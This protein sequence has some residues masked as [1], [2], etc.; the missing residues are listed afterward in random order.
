MK[1]RSHALPLALAILLSTLIPPAFAQVPHFLKPVNYAVPGASMAVLADVNGDGFVDLITA[2]G[3]V[4]TGSG[5]SVLLGKGNGKFG[6]ATTIVDGGNPSYLVVGDFNHDGELDIAVANQPNPNFPLIPPT[7]GG[8]PHNSVSIL[9]G[10]GDGTFKP[11]IDTPTVGA[12]Q[13]VAADFN[14]DGKLDLAVLTG[15][16]S[17]LQI[18]LGNG[19]GTFA[20]NTTSVLVLSAGIFAGDFNHDGKQD[21]LAAGFELL[22]NGDG[23]FTT[24]PA[25]PP[26]SVVGDFNGDGILDLAAVVSNGGGRNPVTFFGETFFG[27][28]DGTW[29]LDGVFSIFTSEGNLIAAN[30]DGDGKLDVFG[31]GSAFPSPANQLLGGLFLGHGDGTFT[32]ASGGI[33]F[34]GFDNS[35]P[36]P[37]FAAEADLDRN[38]SPDVVIADGNG[39]MVALNTFGHPP[40]LAQ[41]TTN[42]KFVVGGAAT[43][44]GTVALGGAAP[45]AGDVIT[46]SASDPSVS[47]PNGNTVAISA[48][49]KKATF[50]IATTSV[51]ALTPVKISASLHSVTQT[52]VLNLVPSFSLASVSLASANPIGMF[53]GDPVSG[54]VTLSGP[55]SDGVVV[56]LV[57][58]N[59]GVLALPASVAVAPGS[60][61]ATFTAIAGFVPA[62]TLVTV[63]GS[64]KGTSKSAAVTVRKETASITITKAEYVVSKSLL[65]IEAAS[66]DRV[67]SLQIYNPATGALLGSIPLVNTGKFSGQLSVHGALTSVAAQSAVGGLGTAA[68]GQK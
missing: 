33:G 59:P 25:I 3:F 20:V 50:T 1:T 30:F 37:D 14:N 7:V 55:A 34:L 26:V 22:G 18:L 63:T 36:F 49:L 64:L 51:A 54:T 6:A 13:M 9:L 35:S 8:P 16:D 2:N 45:A 27:K 52:T 66:T 67:G 40:L 57:S 41:V 62:N 29:P 21:L 48:G 28:A 47:F 32:Q 23:T 68:V 31:P 44:T 61:T 15:E 5:V 24:G 42:S 11:S 46:L 10:N 39:V 65:T 19:D 12:L 43:V 17:P 56:N 60:K 4:F 58:S 38:G 53:G